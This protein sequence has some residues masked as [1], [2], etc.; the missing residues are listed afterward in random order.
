MN[1]DPR[2]KAKNNFEKDFAQLMD[3]TAFGKTREIVRKTQKRRR[4][5]LASEPDQHTTKFFTEMKIK[6]NRNE[7]KNRDTYE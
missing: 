3:N 7:K 4:K 5:Y 6:R 2:K 1:T